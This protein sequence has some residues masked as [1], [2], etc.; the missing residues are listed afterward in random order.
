MRQP[1]KTTI[2]VTPTSLSP[3]PVRPSTFEAPAV[4]PTPLL[5]KLVFPPSGLETAAPTF[6]SP[7]FVPPFSAFEELVTPAES[8][9]CPVSFAIGRYRFRFYQIE[10]QPSR[11]NLPR[12]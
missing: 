11:T 1:D 10:H 4:V 2:P 3:G 8:A 7:R 5:G 6:V 12:C 9:V